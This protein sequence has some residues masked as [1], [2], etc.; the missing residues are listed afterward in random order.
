MF[1]ATSRPNT[2]RTVAGLA[3]L[4][5]HTTVHNIRKSHRNATVGLFMN[6]IQTVIM[7]GAFYLMFTLL[8]ARGTAVRGDF[9]LYLMSGI[10]LFMAHT[11]A[12]SAVVKAEG[13]TSAMMQHAPLNTVVTISAAALSSLYLQVLSIAVVLLLYHVLWNPVVIDKPAGAIGMLLLAWFSGVGIGIILMSAKPWFPEGVVIVSSIYA[14][15]N[16]IASGKMFVANSLPAHILVFFDWNPLF[17][18][19]DQSRG[20][21]FINYNPHFSNITYPLIVSVVLIVLGMMGESYTRKHASL[22]WGA[23]R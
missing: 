1:Q 9:M 5:Y 4:V 12:M 23:G 18:A 15:I 14:R 20:F 13:P 3:E 6:I 19:I 11:K 16:M 8:G 21:I 10:F 7:L 2:E 17:H 22:S